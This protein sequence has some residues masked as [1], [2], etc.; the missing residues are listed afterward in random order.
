MR[1]GEKETDKEKH[2]FRSYYCG[3]CK[4]KKACQL[5]NEKECCACYYQNEQEKAQ[6]YSNYQQVYQRKQQE[7]Q[8]YTQQI[9]L[10]KNYS[11]CQQCGSKEVDAY[12][13]YENNRLVCQPCL[14]TK[15]DGASDP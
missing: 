5:L 3:E 1:D 11:G 2:Q 7:K 12:E 8:A 14:M 9:Q 4:Q 13:L 6:E 15:E 10:L